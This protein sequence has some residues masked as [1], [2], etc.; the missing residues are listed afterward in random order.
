MEPAEERE[1]EAGA[2]GQGGRGTV[3]SW[4]CCVVTVI[5]CFCVTCTLGVIYTFG[6]SLH[7]CLSVPSLCPC[8]FMSLSVSMSLSLSVSLSLSLPVSVSACLYAVSYTHLT[9]P[10]MAVV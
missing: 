1:E 3:W 10:T 9:L 6:N 2:G 5:S 4:F 8:L 7:T